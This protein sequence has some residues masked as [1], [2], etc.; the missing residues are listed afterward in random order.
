MENDF[1]EVGVF[2]YIVLVVWT[3]RAFVL[4]VAELI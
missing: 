4:Y 3:I 2:L 1:K